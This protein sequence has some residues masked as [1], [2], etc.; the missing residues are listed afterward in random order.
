MD[1]IGIPKPIWRRYA[2]VLMP[3]FIAL[4]SMARFSLARDPHLDG[5]IA[6]S[7]FNGTGSIIAYSRFSGLAFSVK[8]FMSHLNKSE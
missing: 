5:R 2:D 6:F 1:L 3:Q 4:V 7:G 8:G